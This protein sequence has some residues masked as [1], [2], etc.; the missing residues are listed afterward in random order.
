MLRKATT[1]LAVAVT[2]STAFACGGTTGPSGHQ[3][4]KQELADE[5]SNTP[6]EEALKRRD[7]FAPLCESD[8]VPAVSQKGTGT[9]VAELCNAMNPPGSKYD[10]GTP[11]TTKADA[12]P[13][14]AS[15]CDLNALNTELSYIVLDEAVTQR[16]HFR[17]LCD[18]KGYPLVGNLNGK[19]VTT[20]S[21]FCG[22]L[23]EKGLL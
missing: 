2:T 7:H 15:G 22:T 4:T 19:V 12:G 14:P 23:K 5:L 1:I 10:A 21:E 16:A 9:T 11:P 6:L 3:E 17:C 18:D 20:A 8:P 13:P